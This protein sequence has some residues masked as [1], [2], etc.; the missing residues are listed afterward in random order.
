[1][2]GGHLPET[3]FDCA[4]CGACCREAFDSVPVYDTDT[5][6]LARQGH[7][8]RVAPDGWRDLLRVPSPTGCGTR[9]GSLTGDGSAGAPFRC[10]MYEDRPSACSELEEGSENCRFARA[11]V[12]L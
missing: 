4:T 11:R 9:C 10:V 7:R 8:I 5:Q 3:L 6:T 12:G 2:R 1:M